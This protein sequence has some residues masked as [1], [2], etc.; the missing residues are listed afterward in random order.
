MAGNCVYSRRPIISYMFFLPLMFAGVE[1]LFSTIFSHFQYVRFLRNKQTFVWR[2]LSDGAFGQ[3]A[4][5]V[6]ELGGVAAFTPVIEHER[7]EGDGFRH[8]QS[9][10]RDFLHQRAAANAGGFGASNAACCVWDIVCEC[11]IFIEQEVHPYGRIAS[12][13]KGGTV[14]RCRNL[15]DS[16]A[17]EREKG[18]V[19]GRDRD[20][21][22]AR[23]FGDAVPVDVIRFDA[24]GDFVT[25]LFEF[26]GAG[27]IEAAA[28]IIDDDGFL[29]FAHLPDKRQRKGIFG[30]FAGKSDDGDISVIL[31]ARHHT[32]YQISVVKAGAKD[33]AGCICFFAQNNRI[34]FQSNPR[35]PFSHRQTHAEAWVLNRAR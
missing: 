30:G 17:G 18:S 33:D 11:V 15:A 20:E 2:E 22:G 10:F 21:Y 3:S 8:F 32:V 14:G 23:V 34:I 5:F 25:A 13:F 19:K 28:I 16:I 27:L 12:I 6:N 24:M 1:Q 4:H 31:A 9:L 29:C 7:A 26:T 35:T